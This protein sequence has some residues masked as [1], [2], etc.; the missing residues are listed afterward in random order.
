MGATKR[1]AEL[2]V[3]HIN[4]RSS[5]AFSMVRFGNVLGSSGSVLDTW[6]KQ[7]ADG[8][9]LTVTDARMTR[10]FM[11]IPEAASLV[12]QSAALI[13][14]NASCGEVFLLNMGDPVRI[15]DMARRFIHL[16]GLDAVMHGEGSRQAGCINIVCT[17]ARPGE[18]LH[19]ELVFDSE[20][21]RPTRHP[22]IVIWELPVPDPDAVG[23][24][25]R[26]LSP[27]KRQKDA[28]LL[29]TEVRALIPEA[30]QPLAA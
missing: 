29:A 16:H 26:R 4:S 17:G 27:G 30:I 8:G 10:Y 3:Q 5:A 9:P 12:I 2:Y 13:D 11:T 28:R 18:K 14:V 21:M 6:A 22:D 24:I 19:E 1:L 25:I 7:I 15:I 23:D 20:A